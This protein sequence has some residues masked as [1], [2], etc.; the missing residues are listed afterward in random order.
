MA[1]S[2]ET[3]AEAH[4][5]IL[6]HKY[7][8]AALVADNHNHNSN[9]NHNHSKS[10]DARFS[11]NIC[12]DAVTEPVVTRCGHLYCWPCLYRWLVPGMNPQERSSLGL[13]PP[14]GPLDTNRRACPVCKA[15]CS[16]PTVV[17]IYVRCSD[18]ASPAHPPRQPTTSTTTAT[19]TNS[20]HA[21]Q[22]PQE[23]NDDLSEDANMLGLD[24]DGDDDNGVQNDVP[25]EI[26]MPIPTTPAEIGLRQRR[27][28]EN[29]SSDVL[30]P[31]RPAPSRHPS[32]D[33]APNGRAVSPT[34]RGGTNH[35][36][37]INHD[38]RPNRH[39]PIPNHDARATLS[40]GL[41][42]ATYQILSRLTNNPNQQPAGTTNPNQDHIPPLHYPQ[43]RDYVAPEVTDLDADPAAN[44]FLSRLYVG[45]A[46]FVLAFLFSC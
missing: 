10:Q 18:D 46:L 22:E 33:S 36:P 7:S 43:R 27:Q 9:H 13:R 40:Y 31:T 24:I 20:P 15:P 39:G 25:R 2:S 1:S 11:C 45:L 4:P 17:P 12:L 41:V 44:V 28:N 19:A 29:T 3:T 35:G 21:A 14:S 38:T 30:V 8:M 26:T 42:L 32:A 6:E 23:A 34:T 16:V 5:P 37:I